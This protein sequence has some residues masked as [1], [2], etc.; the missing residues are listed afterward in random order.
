MAGKALE[1]KESEELD[2][3]RDLGEGWEEIEVSLGEKI[4]WEATPRFV[5]VYTGSKRIEAANPLTGEIGPC[6]VHNFKDQHGDHVYAWG[7]PELDRGL[8]S[9]APGWEVAIAWLGKE[10]VPGTAKTMNKFRVWSKSPA[11]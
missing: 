2:F 8:K 1:K 3:D 9:A 11:I 5:G 7:S 10:K 4:E 6:T